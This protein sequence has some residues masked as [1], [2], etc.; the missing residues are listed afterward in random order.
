MIR[1][2]SRHQV[3]T[4]RTA[5]ARDVARLQREEAQRNAAA[6]SDSSDA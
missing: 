4:E 5:V 1:Y 2:Y 6:E 3:H